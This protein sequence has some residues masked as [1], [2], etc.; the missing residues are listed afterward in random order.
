M[1][2]EILSF[3]FLNNTTTTDI[4]AFYSEGTTEVTQGEKTGEKQCYKESQ[5]KSFEASF[6]D[7]EG[8]SGSEGGEF[9]MSPPPRWRT[10]GER[11][12]RG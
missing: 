8:F 6:K 7:A 3:F 11:G 4:N 9:Q 10:E 1:Y 2:W 5:I 12:Q